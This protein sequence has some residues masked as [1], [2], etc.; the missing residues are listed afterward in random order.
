LFVALHECETWCVILREEHR[1]RVPQNKV[2]QN[3]FM[4]RRRT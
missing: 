2:L 3:V 4:P 1:Q